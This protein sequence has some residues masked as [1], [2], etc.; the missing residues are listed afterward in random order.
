MSFVPGAF[1]S[2]CPSGRPLT[3]SRMSGRRFLPPTMI[4]NWLTA[5]NS[6]LP[7]I[8]EVDQPCVLVPLDPVLVLVGHRHARQQ[9]IVERAVI[10]DHGRRR[11][12]QRHVTCPLHGLGRQMRVDPRDRP[13]QPL[14]QHHIRPQLALA[15]R[16]VGR[17]LG[18]VNVSP[19]VRDRSSRASAGCSASV[20]SDAAC[21]VMTPRC[22]RLSHR[23]DHLGGSAVSGTRISPE[24]SFGS[25]ASRSERERSRL[26]DAELRPAQSSGGA[27]DRLELAQH[28]G[29]GAAVANVVDVSLPSVDPRSFRSSCA[30]NERKWSLIQPRARTRRAR[31]RHADQDHERRAG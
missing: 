3:Y 16:S 21:G 8:V 20:S 7:G 19:A 2:I 29:S 5:R 24:I 11:A 25:S 10:L 18:A 17:E 4:V 1:S 31:S 30:S 22:E 28:V 9:Q 26:R 6:L 27:T 12:R 13:P 23:L 15:G 14:D